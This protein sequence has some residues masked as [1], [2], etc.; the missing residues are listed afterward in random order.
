MLEKEIIMNSPK[1]KILLI[2][3]GGTIASKNASN[4]LTPMITSEEI[5]NCVPEIKDFCTIDT[6][7]LFNIDSTNIYYP[8]WLAMAQCVEAHY[9]QYDGFVITH[10]T[11]TM[12]YTA[13]ALS[14]LIQNNQKPVVIT[15]SQKSI[16]AKESDARLNL[17]DAFLYAIDE[18]AC[19]VHILFD[20]KI[21]LGTRSRKV[22]TKSFNAFNSIDYPE[23]GIIRN[24]KILLYVTEYFE[25]DTPVFY[26]EL[27]PSV[28]VLRLTPGLT[29]EILRSIAPHFDA[30][31]IESYG[32]GGVPNYG[33]AGFEKA[34]E[35]FIHSGKTIIMSTQV[36][37][38]GSDMEVYQ[39]GQSIKERLDLIEAYS[40]TTEAIVTKLMW[41]LAQTKEPSEIRE[42][43]Y[44]PI[45]HDIITF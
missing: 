36:P 38:E 32:V 42:L 35:E 33:N 39:V 43:F 34:I 30:V 16:A 15:G 25:H 23:I 13:C 28:F 22:R 37:H 6:I 27:N 18:R 12:A 4:G 24:N 29:P 11:D 8:H 44:K 21:L 45:M 5:I 40:M 31:V 19:G 9:N 2:A 3:T 17:L 41:I 26:H 7:Q 10:G 20:H 1:K 14:Y